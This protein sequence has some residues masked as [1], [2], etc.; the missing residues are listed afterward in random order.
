V[1]GR[2]FIVGNAG[3]GKTTLA[4]EVGG[5]LGAPVHSLDAVVWRS[6]WRKTPQAVKDERLRDLAATG[7]WVIDGVSERVEQAAD[8]VIFLDVSPWVA[9]WRCARRNVRF[10]FRS[11]PELPAGC[12]EWRIVARL[13][14]IIWRF[15]RT[16]RPQI[17]ARAEQEPSRYVHVRTAAD[18]ERAL[19]IAV[20]FGR[21]PQ[22]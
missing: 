5:R 9:T 4:R 20:A 13:V 12:P 10:L 18:R 7:H 21:G 19:H 1:G 16:V 17:L 22:A 6:G 8:L 11:R 14:R 2:V 3:A 15:N